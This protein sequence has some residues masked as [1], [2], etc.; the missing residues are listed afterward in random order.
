MTPYGDIKLSWH[1][2]ADYKTRVYCDDRQ[3]VRAKMKF[4]AN[5]KY[6]GNILRDTWPVCLSESGPWPRPWDHWEPWQQWPTLLDVLGPSAPHTT[7]GKQ[8]LRW[9]HNGHDGVSNHQPHHC[10]LNR[11]V[12]R[13]SKTTS[14]L[15]VASL[16]AG[17]SPVT[18]EFPAQMASNAENVSFDDVIMKWQLGSWSTLV[19]ITAC[20]Q[21]GAKPLSELMIT[22]Y[23][24]DTKEYNSVKIYFKF[25]NFHPRKCIWKYR[26]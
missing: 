19:Q 8:T 20:L 17:N 22:S 4:S 18:G 5:L 11:L 13:R 23:Q 16:C 7:P 15:R 6:N 14:K 10:L 9:H 25:E 12:R 21:F 2:F 24:L 1:C 3:D 26:Q